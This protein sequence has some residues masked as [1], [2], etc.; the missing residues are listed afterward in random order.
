MPAQHYSTPYMLALSA[1]QYT[2]D[3]LPLN[4]YIYTVPKKGVQQLSNC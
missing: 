1:H 2:A 3:L 4:F